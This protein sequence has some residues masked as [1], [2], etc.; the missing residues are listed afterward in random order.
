MKNSILS[1]IIC[2]ILFANCSNNNS[3]IQPSYEGFI[4]KDT[5]NRMIQSYLNSIDSL[6]PE[7]G[8]D[9]QQLYSLIVGADELRTYLSDTSIKNVKVMFA[10]TLDYINAGNGNRP[11]GLKSGALT[12]VFG[13]FDKEGNYVYAPGMKVPDMAKACP[14]KC[15]TKGTASN[16]LFE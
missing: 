12:I 14:P 4:Y 6:D 16:N 9:N 13:G 3:E 5:A 2:V 8:A 11:A 15:P 1:G 7:G 10:H